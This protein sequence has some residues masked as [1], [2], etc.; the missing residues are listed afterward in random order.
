MTY[1]GTLLISVA[2]IATLS[3]LTLPICNTRKFLRT[4]QSQFI[5]KQKMLEAFCVYLASSEFYNESST[6]LRV[7]LSNLP[8]VA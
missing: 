5:L 1:A 7:A 8:N 4:K 6:N 3:C 2:G